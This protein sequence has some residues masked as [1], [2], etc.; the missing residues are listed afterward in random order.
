MVLNDLER[1]LLE[2]RNNQQAGSDLPQISPVDVFTHSPT[3]EGQIK[4]VRIY[5]M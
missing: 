5:L 3:S 1:G 2:R 4:L